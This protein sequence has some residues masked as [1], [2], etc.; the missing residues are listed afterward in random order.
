M[1]HDNSTSVRMMSYDDSGIYSVDY[2]NSSDYTLQHY[3]RN[4]TTIAK[5]KDDNSHFLIYA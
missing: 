4:A 1:D 5:I 3:H 2:T